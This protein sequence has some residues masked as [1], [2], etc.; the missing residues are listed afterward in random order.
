MVRRRVEGMVESMREAMLELRMHRRPLLASTML[1]LEPV[2]LTT[3]EQDVL[4]LLATGMA[5]TQIAY[6]LKI[7]VST[8][9]NTVKG[10]MRK[11][12]VE[13]RIELVRLAL[14]NDLLTE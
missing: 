11:V 4:N 9:S 3:T 13:S 12:G 7:A 14:D 8:V 6:T 1:L 2:S 5:D 10:L